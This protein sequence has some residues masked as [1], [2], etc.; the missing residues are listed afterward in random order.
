MQYVFSIPGEHIENLLAEFSTYD[1]RMPTNHY[2]Q[3]FIKQSLSFPL[4]SK[5]IFDI[6]MQF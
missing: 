4:E 6:F 3:I 1:I 5:G 2:Y